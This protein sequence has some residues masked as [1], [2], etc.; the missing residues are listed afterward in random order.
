MINGRYTVVKNYGN[1]HRLT[2]NLLVSDKIPHLFLHVMYG[3]FSYHK[4]FYGNK[5]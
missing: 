1:G 3:E 5:E 2:Q 4:S